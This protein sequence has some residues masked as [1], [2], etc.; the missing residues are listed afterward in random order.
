[1]SKLTPLA[2]LRTLDG[3]TYVFDPESIS[4]VA[5][6]NHI[7]PDGTIAPLALHVWG[8]AARP[9]PIEGTAQVF[10]TSLK[11]VDEF[12][13]LTGE[14]GAVHIRADAIVFMIEPSAGLGFSD[15]KVKCL[16][17]LG[18]EPAQFF[19]VREDVATVRRLVDTIR[20]RPQCDDVPRA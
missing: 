4:G 3:T 6:A 20:T 19:Q 7:R 12:V 10:L 15:R 17:Y 1:M 14:H 2:E 16:V 9:L 18:T 8:I 13:S 11:M 5:I